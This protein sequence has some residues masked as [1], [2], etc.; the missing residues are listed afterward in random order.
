MRH[1]E[2]NPEREV[3]SNIGLLKETEKFQV[4]NLTLHLQE[5]DEQQK[6]PE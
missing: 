2:G 1:S 3:Q 4:N 6:S 5:L